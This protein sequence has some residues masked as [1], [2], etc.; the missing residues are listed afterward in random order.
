MSKE[1]KNILQEKFEGFE[2]TPTKD[3][4]AGI[5]P[6]IQPKRR[7]API[8]WYAA[9][10]AAAILIAVVLWPGSAGLKDS[11]SQMAVVTEESTN[12]FSPEVPEVT[13][14]EVNPQLAE[15]TPIA[16]LPQPQR[17][18]NA[19]ANNDKQ[20]TTNYKPVINS[21]FP[22]TPSQTIEAKP[23]IQVASV[24]LP[25]P[26]NN[27]SISQAVPGEV[28]IKTSKVKHEIPERLSLKNLDLAEI[29]P[30]S[31]VSFASEK[32]DEWGV[33][34][35][36]LYQEEKSQKQTKS[37]FQLMLGKFSITHTSH[38]SI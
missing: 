26:T 21:S 15:V 13:P 17:R 24:S 23:M 9:A 11:P 10:A 2:P 33:R 19:A 20:Q 1:I 27:I 8:V 14:E 38:K 29:T 28:E 36:I 35:P 32:L 31:M 5:E 3:L 4:W 6:E 34:S 18:V 30:T 12:E 25:A 37:R 16:P 22:T 7:I